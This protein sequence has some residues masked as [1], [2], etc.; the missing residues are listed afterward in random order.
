MLS[1]NNDN[2]RFSFD[3]IKQALEWLLQIAAAI[4]HLHNTVNI[5][6][7][8][9][10]TKNIFIYRDTLKLGNFSFSKFVQENLKRTIKT[11]L[12]VYRYMSPEMI[13]N[14]TYNTETVNKFYYLLIFL[15]NY[16]ILNHHIKGYLV[17]WMSFI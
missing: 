7:R 2:D 13:N 14:E 9:L 12:N 8:D 11:D 15:I 10:R 1:Q 5:L 6:H 3:Y 16:K 4:H 17:I